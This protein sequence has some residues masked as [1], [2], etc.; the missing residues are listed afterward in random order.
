M[1]GPSWLAESFATPE[2]DGRTALNSTR[3]KITARTRAPSGKNQVTSENAFVV[4]LL[5]LAMAMSEAALRYLRS[6]SELL[7]RHEN[8]L[9]S[10]LQLTDC[11]CVGPCRANSS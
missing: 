8:C 9:S 2:G 10:P 11:Q 3:A 1:L 5:L 7:H 4:A 6:G